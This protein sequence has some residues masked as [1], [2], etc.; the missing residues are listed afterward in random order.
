MKKRFG[1]IFAV[2][3]CICSL[4][5]CSNS[6]TVLAKEDKIYLG[7]MPAGFTMHTRGAHVVGLC[8]V[9]T[10]NGLK[11]P[12]KDCDIV[13]GDIILSIDGCDVNNASDIEK[14]ITN[15]NSVVVEIKRNGETSMKNLKPIKD[16]SGNAKI[17]VFIR[18]DVS[19]IGT[20]TYIKRN[21]FASLGHPAINDNGEILEISGGN[22][23]ECN[24]T[25]YIKGVRGKAG[26]LRGVFLKNN[27]QGNIDKNLSCGVYGEI[28]E[29]F[30]VKD[31]REIEVGDAK[32]GKAEMYTTITGN[33]PSK[34]DISIVKVDT[35]D[36]D[37]NFVIKVDDVFLLEEVGGIVQGM[38][39]SPIV[40]NGKL[41]G[42]VTHV[43]INDPT[44]G[45]GISIYKMINN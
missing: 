45:F 41:V 10:E 31:L 8:D 24:V 9:I 44:R 6:L 11:S 2:F 25:G 4:F 12:A 28:N 30:A 3:L 43:F 34:Y 19:G 32:P 40:Q 17:G 36:G 22:I 16:M 38:S 20:I 37:K 15:K 39:G 29:V 33:T 18:N 26:E 5:V 35:N 14:N 23:F 1:F 27:S 21:R 13:V 42:A 7:G